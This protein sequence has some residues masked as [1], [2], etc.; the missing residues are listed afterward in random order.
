[1]HPILFEFPGLT[2]YTQTVLVIAAFMAGLMLAVHESRQAEIAQCELTTVVLVG[3]IGSIVGAR[4]FFLL[5]AWNAA[6]LTFQELYLLGQTDGGFA[7]HGG[8]MFGGFASWLVTRHYRVSVWRMG[9]VLAPGLALALF[10][11][12]LGCLMNG[13]DFG[14]PTSQPWAI[15]LHGSPRHPIQLYEGVGSLALVPFLLFLNRR[16]YTPG[17]TLLWYLCLSSSLRF[18][19]DIFRDD[20][21]RY[22]HLTIPQ[23]FAFGLAAAAGILLRYRAGR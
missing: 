13:C 14:V 21:F 20:P 4:L 2:L 6:H 12:R 1:M 11:L 15:M 19:V 18:C 7:F 22:W 16:A 10:F 3:F 8:L 9:D 17:T 23:F 5:L